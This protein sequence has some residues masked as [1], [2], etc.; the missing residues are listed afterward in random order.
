MPQTS[1][2]GKP[3]RWSSIGRDGHAEAASDLVAA[4]VAA[5]HPKEER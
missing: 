3:K 4:F 2:R 5:R 1:I